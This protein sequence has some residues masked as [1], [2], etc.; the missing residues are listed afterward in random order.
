MLVV[1]ENENEL[2]DRQKKLTSASSG[3]AFR[4]SV[5]SDPGGRAR[6]D[7]SEN[8]NILSKVRIKSE[9]LSTNF[10]FPFYL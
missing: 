2:K 8:K 6:Y 10:L 5:G 9:P 3:F 4:L 1:P 7:A